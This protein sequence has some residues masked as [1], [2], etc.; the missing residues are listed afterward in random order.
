MEDSSLLLR[1]E[2]VCPVGLPPLR[3]GWVR[4]E[5]DVVTAVGQGADAPAAAR[6]VSLGF[7]AILPGLVNAHT[8]L[9]LSWLRG[10]VPPGGDFLT[11]VGHLMRAR[12]SF[13][14][15]DDPVAMAAV[16]EAVDEMRTT[17]TVAV[18]DISNA[19]VTPAVLAE[20]WMPGVVFHE[21]TGF[22]DGDG[23]AAV[24]GSRARRAALSSSA[25]RVVTA[26]HAPFS[27]SPELFLAI[28]DEAREASRPLT[29]VHVAESAAE[30]QLLRDGTGPWRDRLEALGV[31]RPDWAPPGT[32]P[33]DYL[34]D[35]GVIDAGTLVVHGVQLRDDELAR[36][37]ACG[38]TLVTCPR[39]NMWVGA[40]APPLDRFFASGVAMAVGT[41]SLASAPDLN[42]FSEL[43]EL[44]RLAPGVAPRRLIEAATLGGAAALQLGHRLGT[45]APGKDARLIAVSLP[46]GT[47]DPE[48]AL[49]S[50]VSADRIRWVGTRS[51]RSA[52]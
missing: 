15:A 39:S 19:L 23:R 9:E 12:T 22:R 38:A 48:Y 34:C 46:D 47:A 42:M 4:V 37:A 17:G 2:W 32:G 5:G 21:L 43:A 49:V 40:G 20:M 29:S 44:H 27:V 51:S 18:G 8:H 13:E 25:V 28:R 41:D 52:T 24:A 26:P 1:A 45:I 35:L 30:V 36:V 16:R 33:G 10:R 6:E 11:W 3:H 7:A 50:G 14:S 31:W